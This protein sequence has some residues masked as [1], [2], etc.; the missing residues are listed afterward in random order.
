MVE[1][2]IIGTDFCQGDMMKLSV[3]EW[4][5]LGGVVMLVAGLVFVFQH[6]AE[7]NAILRSLLE[8]F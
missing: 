1:V 8:K 3:V 4:V 2:E 5:S 6:E 7:I